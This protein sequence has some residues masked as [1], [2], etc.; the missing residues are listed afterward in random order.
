MDR[1][2]LEAAW[3]Q[4]DS[5]DLILF[6]QNSQRTVRPVNI[7]QAETRGIEVA[8][9]ASFFGHLDLTANYTW[10]DSENRSDIPFLRGNQLPGVPEQELFLRLDLYNTRLRG[11]YEFVG[12]DDNFLDQ[13]N[14]E[15]VQDRKVHNAGVSAT[16]GESLI[17]TFE[18]KNITDE[19]ISDVL[20][21]PLPGRAWFG[22]AVLKL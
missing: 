14:F 15:N 18:L 4:S 1:L 9:A 2:S 11:W 6:E 13:A 12:S 19:R 8:A 21:F 20:G 17:L 10:I 5:N 22:R 16:W 3:F 7:S